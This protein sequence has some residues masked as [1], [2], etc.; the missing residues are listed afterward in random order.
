M[1][2]SLIFSTGD[3]RKTYETLLGRVREVVRGHPVDNGGG[4]KS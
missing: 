1:G 3:C 4:V 2:G